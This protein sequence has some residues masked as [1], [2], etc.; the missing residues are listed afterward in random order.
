MDS[1]AKLPAFGAGSLLEVWLC[2]LG[3]A[4]AI[5]HGGADAEGTVRPGD[6]DCLF[7][8]GVAIYS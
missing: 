3:D 6:L 5:P 7:A 8:P 2:I 4:L 1:F